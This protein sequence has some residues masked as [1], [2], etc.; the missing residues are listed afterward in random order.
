MSCHNILLLSEITL[1]IGITLLSLLIN[2]SP[3]T[4]ANGKPVP[5][6]GS[7]LLTKS[8]KNIIKKQIGFIKRLIFQ[9]SHN[10]PPLCDRC[11]AKA[12]CN[13]YSMDTIQ[14][15]SFPFLL[16][17][18]IVVVKCNYFDLLPHYITCTPHKSHITQHI[19]PN[20]LFAT[21]V[22]EETQGCSSLLLLW[23]T[24]SCSAINFVYPCTFT[25]L[26]AFDHSMASS[27][28]CS[29]HWQIGS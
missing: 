6:V 23:V 28:F 15:P 22:Q 19:M 10:R 5:F 24:F 12:I 7:P 18:I 1:L 8:V 11:R 26:F 29:I 14:Y 13:W 17:H 3:I 20:Y 16:P 2:L 27:I 4:T 21:K 9:L 25:R